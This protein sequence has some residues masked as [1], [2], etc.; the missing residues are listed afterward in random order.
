MAGGGGL[1]ASGPGKSDTQG[2]ISPAQMALTQF[3]FG[4]G[5][6]RNAAQ[7]GQGGMGMSTNQTMADAGS[8]MKQAQEAQQMSQSDAQAMN[9]FNQQQKSGLSSGIGA[10]GSFA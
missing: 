5:A 8:Y 4:Q 9:A 6:L 10:I 2:G 7:F 3:D 1:G